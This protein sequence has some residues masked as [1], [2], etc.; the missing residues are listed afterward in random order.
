MRHVGRADADGRGDELPVAQLQ[1]RRPH[2]PRHGHPR[3]DADDEG[4]GREGAGP[5]ARQV[6][7]AQEGCQQDQDEEAWE[8]Q[9]HLG[10]AHQA[11]VH[12]AAV[13]PA[14]SP[15]MVPSVIATAIA[16]SPR[17]A[18]CGRHRRCAPT[19]RGPTR[20]SP[21]S[22]VSMG[23]LQP[24]AQ[25]LLGRRVAGGERRG[26]DD[27]DDKQHDHGADHGHPV[28]PEPPPDGAEQRGLGPAACDQKRFVHGRP[29]WGRCDGV[30]RVQ[31]SAYS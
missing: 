23:G 12:R 15:M 24:V 7:F 29:G 2:Q 20:R 3:Q 18:R 4:D 11:V 1:R 25:I 13:K 6:R 30:A 27:Q 28:P 8:G 19:R 16:S 26:C 17:S 10:E 31:C 21:A 22:A 14:A 9:E 5:H